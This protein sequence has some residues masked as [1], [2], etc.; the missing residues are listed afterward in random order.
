MTPSSYYQWLKRDWAKAGFVLAVF[1]FVFLFVLVRPKDFVL[2]VI[3]LQTPLYLI[4][5]TEEYVFPGGF[6]QFFN[7]YIYKTDPENGPFDEKVVFFINMGYVWIP[8]PVFGLLSV[9]NYGFGAWIPYFT[10]YQG[11]GHIGLALAARKLYNPGM[12]VSL[13]VNIPVGLW[14][15]IVLVNSGVVNGYFLNA[16]SA[17][18]FGLNATLPVV[19]IIVLRNYK[20]RQQA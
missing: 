6:A 8:L 2:F 15:I 20:R 13:L 7:R 10:F 19:G 14:S 4:H 5:E 17:I 3:L 18:G 11:F 1:L 12:V 9:V 16:S